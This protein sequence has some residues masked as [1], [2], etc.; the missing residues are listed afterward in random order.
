MEEITCNGCGHK[1]LEVINIR[2]PCPKCGSLGSRTRGVVVCESLGVQ[3]SITPTLTDGS[4]GRETTFDKDEKPILDWLDTSG[5]QF[6]THEVAKVFIRHLG[7]ISSVGGINLPVYRRRY[8][9]DFPNG[10]ASL[11]FGPPPGTVTV[12]G[13][14]NHQ[15]NPAL[16]LSDSVEGVIRELNHKNNRPVVIQEYLLPLDNLKI[17]DFSTPGLANHINILFCNIERGDYKGNGVDRDLHEHGA[18][19]A[20]IVRGHGFHGMRIPGVRGEPG[21][22]YSNIVMFDPEPDWKRWVNTVTLPLINST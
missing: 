16:Y 3:S 18:F 22:H 7:G 6:K 8:L 12:L 17:A 4:T 21:Q 13:R 15:G 20:D 5:P 19:I 9:D 11:D 2:K 1:W 10:Y 14:Y